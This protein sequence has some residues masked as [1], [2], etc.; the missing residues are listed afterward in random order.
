MPTASINRPNQGRLIGTV[1]RGRAGLPAAPPAARPPVVAPEASARP[2]LKVV[3]ARLPETKKRLLPS[4]FYFQASPTDALRWSKSHAHQ[5]Y[6]T[7]SAGQFSRPGGR[8]LATIN[9]GSLFV[10]YDPGWA[11]YHYGTDRGAPPVDV[12]GWT[13]TLL[14]ILDSGTPIAVTIGQP[15]LWGRWDVRQLPMTLRNL[16]VEERA[17]ENDARYFDVQMTEWRRQTLAVKRRGL[18]VTVTL[19]EFGDKGTWD[20]GG[21]RQ[22]VRDPTLTKLAR[23]FYGDPTKWRTIANHPRNQKL[24]AFSGARPLVIAVRKH[25]TGKKGDRHLKVY[26]PELPARE[27][28]RGDADPSGVLG[29]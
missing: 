12:L 15:R 23:K 1:G 24:R 17:G 26:V 27:A 19:H 2:T 10:D 13:E 22:S 21:G 16:E 14:D 29:A 8:Q 5:E 3:F 9:F 4:P 7:V 6:E 28:E 25:G 18:P 20:A 11:A